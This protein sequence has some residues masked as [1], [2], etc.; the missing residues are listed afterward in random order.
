[1]DDRY[2]AGAENTRSAQP[3]RVL[4][5]RVGKT[6]LGKSNC[7]TPNGRMRIGKRRDGKFVIESLQAIE[8]PQGVD[9]R[10]GRLALA[11]QRAQRHGPEPAILRRHELTAI[12]GGLGGEG[13][14]GG[15]DDAAAHQVVDRLATEGIVLKAF[16]IDSPGVNRQ[17]ASR[18]EVADLGIVNMK[19]VFGDGIDRSRMIESRGRIVGLLNGQ[20][21]VLF[22]VAAFDDQ[23]AN[24]VVVSDRK[25]VAPIVERV[26]V[27]RGIA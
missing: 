15:F 3:R 7:L 16:G 11:Q 12:I 1:M 26:A 10:C 17:A 23:V 18:C 14:A 22:Q 20:K 27:L 25:A 5:R 4:K 8:R 21:R 9:A 6:I 13:G 2:V 19:R 24:V